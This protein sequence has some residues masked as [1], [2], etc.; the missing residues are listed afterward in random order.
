VNGNE[1][2]TASTGTPGREFCRTR[3]TDQWPQWRARRYVR[4]WPW[5]ADSLAIPFG[6]ER[7][8]A[9]CSDV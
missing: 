5:A 9:A 4:S 1:R 6:R 8:F 3:G 7:P 2:I